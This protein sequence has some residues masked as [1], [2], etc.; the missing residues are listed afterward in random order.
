MPRTLD[1]SNAIVNLFEY[2]PSG[3]T[4]LL[5]A[6]D[7]SDD[8]NARISSAKSS[9]KKAAPRR[10]IRSPGVQDSLI[11]SGEHII[12]IPMQWL[13]LMK[14]TGVLSTQHIQA[15]HRLQRKPRLPTL[16]QARRTALKR[17]FLMARQTR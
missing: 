10:T 5:M 11:S 9:V 17:A 14:A 12:S 2:T 7:E 15:G 16:P 4:D 13:E 8:V 3:S 1:S 6:I